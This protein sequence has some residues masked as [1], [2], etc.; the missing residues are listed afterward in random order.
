MPTKYLSVHSQKHYSPVVLEGCTAGQCRMLAGYTAG[1]HHTS[2][3]IG[4]AEGT[5]EKIAAVNTVAEDI[6]EG[7][8]LHFHMAAAEKAG[9][10][11]T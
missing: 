4:S 1:Q 7:M 6:V 10:A 5:V 8:H 2:V 3:T 9:L 11:Y